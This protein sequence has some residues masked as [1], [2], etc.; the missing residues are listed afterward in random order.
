MPRQGSV[1]HTDCTHIAGHQWMLSDLCEGQWFALCFPLESFLGEPPFLVKFWVSLL[2]TDLGK[3]P[4]QP[5]L[6]IFRF[7]PLVQVFLAENSQLCS[8]GPGHPLL[9]E[10]EL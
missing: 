1:P 4:L 3:N 5:F 9:N 2:Y 10:T 8:P 7:C 6:V